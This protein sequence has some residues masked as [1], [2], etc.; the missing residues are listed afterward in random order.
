MAGLIPFNRRNTG[1]DNFYNMVDDFFNDAWPSKRSLMNDTFKVDVKEDDE[2]YTIDADL[3][4]IK[5]EEINLQLDD[6]RLTISINREES[7]EEEK[8]NYIHKERCYMSM[9]RSLYLADSSN[10]DISAK[11]D[12]GVLQIVIPK[13]KKSI[14]TKQIEIQ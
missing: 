3:P 4:G 11:L 7:S 5:K 2:K 9:Q 13:E 6:G 1:I 8:R 14:N 10:D 12:E